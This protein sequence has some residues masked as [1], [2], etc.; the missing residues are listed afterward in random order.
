VIEREYV[1]APEAGI[2]MRIVRMD[3]R[4]DHRLTH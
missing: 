4:V 3:L 2:V 1:R